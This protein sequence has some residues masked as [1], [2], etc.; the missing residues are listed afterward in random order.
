MK[1]GKGLFGTI[2]GIGAA[3]LGYGT[4]KLVSSKN[5]DSEVE[6]CDCEVVD[7]EGAEEY[8]DCE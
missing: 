3:L 8:E 1:H 2:I 5:A 7:E 6:D 4:Y